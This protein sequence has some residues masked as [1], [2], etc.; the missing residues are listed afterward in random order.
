MDTTSRRQT[1]SKHKKTLNSHISTSVSQFSQFFSETWTCSSFSGWTCQLIPGVN[2]PRIWRSTVSRWLPGSICPT[3]KRGRPH[4]SM[5]LLPYQWMSDCARWYSKS[6]FASSE[7]FGAVASTVSTGKD[8]YKLSRTFLGEGTSPTENRGSAIF[9][10]TGATVYALRLAFF[11][12]S[13]L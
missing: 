8:K 4:V 11:F 1:K 9:K 6:V 12:F 3:Q 13:C 2:C 10:V 5:P 7:L